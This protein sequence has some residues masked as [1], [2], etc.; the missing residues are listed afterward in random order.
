MDSGNSEVFNDSEGVFFANIYAFDNTTDNDGRISV[1]DGTSSNRMSIIYDKL[2]N[3]IDANIFSGGSEQFQVSHSININQYNKA[4]IKYKVNDCSLWV[5]GFEVATDASANMPS[6]LNKIN[7]ASEI[8]STRVLEGKTKE[9]GYY[10]D[11]ILTDLE[12]EYTDKLPFIKRNGNRIKFK[13][14]II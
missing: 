3:E 4:L 13:R 2:N 5:N 11:S 12:L 10:D 14:T 6:G 9:I 8:G 7:L 1:S